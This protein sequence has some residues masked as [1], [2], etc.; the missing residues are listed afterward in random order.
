MT[1]RKIEISSFIDALTQL[2]D[3]GIDYVD[4]KR[5]REVNQDTIVLSFYQDYVSEEAREEFNDI[6]D[7][8]T[9]NKDND[10][11]QIDFK[12]SDDDLNQLT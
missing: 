9:K 4:I 1:I 11:P 7:Q 12:L 6:V 10:S 3:M 5:V 8:L 2:Y